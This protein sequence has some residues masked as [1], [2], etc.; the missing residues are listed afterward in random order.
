MLE[1]EGLTKRFGGVTAL[2]GV[3]LDV[4]AGRVHALLGEN[5]AGKSTL[6]KCLSG[7]HRADA[8][9]MRLS[10]KAYEPASPRTAETAG[11]RTVHQELNLV[12]GFTAYENAYVG[13][14]YPRRFGRVDWKAMRARFAALRDRYRLD[15]DIDVE[16]GG[17][18]IEHRDTIAHPLRI[19][20]ITHDG[21]RFS[22]LHAVVD[23]EDVVA[24]RAD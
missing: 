6:L 4:A 16:P 24:I 23:S 10:G 18:G 19:D 1:I 11:L 2:D 12:P 3:R 7:V 20:A 15:L 9:T 8:G 22:Q 17:R 5:G 13:R 21:C 14:A